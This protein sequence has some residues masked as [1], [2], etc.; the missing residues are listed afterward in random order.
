MGIELTYYIFEGVLVGKAGAQ[1]IHMVAFSGGGGGSTRHPP[2]DS[3]N[4]PYMTALKMTAKNVTPHVH[5]GALPIGDYGIDRP[6]LHPTLGPS[7][8][9]TP[10]KGQTMFGRDG[11]FIH[12]RGPHG[13]DGCIVPSSPAD[14]V[15]LLSILES[16]Q[17]G[18][19]HV[20]EAM[21]GVR[22][23]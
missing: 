20:R 15:R 10:S 23:A 11:F 14:L 9:L 21:G 12:G 18:L 5:G 22:F 19:L 16:S 7:A 17:G 8:R 1:M 2:A 3:T 13:S 6:K 4:N